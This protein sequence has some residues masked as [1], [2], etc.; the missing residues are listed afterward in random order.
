[1]P[2]VVLLG[3]GAGAF[4]GSVGL[5]TAFSI[6]GSFIL[7]GALTYGGLALATYLLTPKPPEFDVGANRRD[8]RASLR[9]AIAPARWV[10]GRARVGSV[11]AYYLEPEGNDREAYMVLVLCEGPIEGVE[12]VWID[13]KEIAWNDGTTDHAVG[14][15]GD[16]IKEFVSVGSSDYSYTTKERRVREPAPEASKEPFDPGGSRG[17]RR[18]EGPGGGDGGGPDGDDPGDAGGGPD[19]TEDLVY[20]VD[21]ESSALRMKFFYNGAEGLSARFPGNFPDNKWTTDHKLVGKAVVLVQLYQPSYGMDASARLWSRLPH[22]EFL[23]KG[24]KI[25]HPTAAIPTWTENAAAIRYW[26]LTKRRALP[27][28]AIHP[29]DY[30]HAYDVCEEIVTV[31]LPADYIDYESSGPRY[32]INGV[33]YADDDHETVEAEMDFAWSGYALEINGSYRFRPGLDRPITITIDPED[34]MERGADIAAPSLSDRINSASMRIAQSRSHDFTEFAIPEYRDEKAIVRDGKKLPKD[35]QSRPYICCPV[36]AGR[37]LAIMLRR[38]RANKVY[39]RQITPGDMFEKL[40]L[41]P[42]DRVT[43]NDPEHGLDNVP[44]VITS[45]TMNEDWSININFEEA[46]DDIYTPGLVLPPLLS[47]LYSDRLFPIDVL[48]GPNTPANIVIYAEAILTE[49]Y[50][51]HSLVH[52]SWDESPHRTRIF[53][54]LVLSR[55]PERFNFQDEKIVS[56]VGVVF[57]VPYEGVY[58]VTLWHVDIRNVLS[59]PYTQDI[60]I[61]WSG[62]N[63]IPLAE[64]VNE[65]IGGNPSFQ[66][67][68][69]EIAFANTAADRAAAAVDRAAAAVD[70]GLAAAALANTAA[71]RAAAA[72]LLSKDAATASSGSASSAAGS[73]TLSEQEATTSGDEAAA[74]ALSATAAAARATSARGSAT[75]SAASARTAS[76]KSTLATQ[77]AT[78]ASVDAVKA[79]TKATDAEGSAD[80]SAASARTASAKSTL[81]AQEATAASRDAVTASTQATNARGSATDAEGSADAS[82]ASARTASSKSTLATQEASAASLDA[83]KASTQATNARG[84]AAASAASARTASSKSTLATQKANAASLDAVKASTQATASA[85]SATASAA[86]ALTASAKSTL[87]TQEASAASGDAVKASTKADASAASADASAASAL[88]ASS[89][90]TE[91]AQE[92]SAASV[93]AVKASTKATEASASSSRAAASATSASGSSA[94]AT[95]SQRAAAG[96]AGSAASSVAGLTLSV[97]AEVKSV[98]GTTYAAAVVL[99]AKAGSGGAQLELVAFSNLSGSKSSAKI[100]ADSFIVD[101]SNFRVNSSGQLT[102]HSITADEIKAGTITAAE[103]SNTTGILRGIVVLP[104][105]ITGSVGIGLSKRFDRMTISSTA[106]TVSFRSY[107]SY[108]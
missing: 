87:A 36:A 24:Q 72:A 85:A 35:F 77:E 1:M 33:I 84:S 40:S 17:N 5:F 108:R 66:K 97:A 12:R 44:V 28:D 32:T 50:T 70:R 58:R 13:G 102:V 14:A 90:S 75:A 31:K 76:A 6:G 26:W 81:A 69:E 57:G 105:N 34:I 103:I 74:A 78:A 27:S 101:A 59:K 64:R 16:I 19:V 71:D 61:D 51:A 43:L 39:S 21:V 93:D 45:R 98:I 67:L 29:Q 56:G 62:L 49:D 4:F 18:R 25:S 48:R 38:A 106:T 89:K 83:V 68:E 42:T 65:F 88:T 82:A 55:D 100:R 15:T 73:A 94:A 80:A 79:S 37:L 41:I 47:S 96:S 11:L 91:A 104:E 54:E 22:F 7:A 8:T 63:I 9:V 60:S 23:V 30:L 2:P 10:M 107:F 86:S 99:R 92:A 53:I 52:V 20:Y 3:V 46:P 95:I